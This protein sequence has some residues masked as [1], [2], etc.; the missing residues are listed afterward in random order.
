MMDQPSPFDLLN[1]V[2]CCNEQIDAALHMLS[3][4]LHAEMERQQDTDNVPLRDR[5]YRMWLTLELIRQQYTVN[6]KRFHDAESRLYQD[7][8]QRRCAK[9]S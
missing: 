9:S 3:E 5:L 8:V 2:G 4:E 1:D 6:D 7:G